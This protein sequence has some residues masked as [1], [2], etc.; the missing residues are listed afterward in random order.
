LVSNI[1]A[2][3]APPYRMVLNRGLPFHDVPSRPDPESQRPLI[4]MRA[5]RSAGL[6]VEIDFAHDTISVW[7]P[8]MTVP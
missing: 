5:L 8:D 6:K 2:L 1:P 4:G 7:T 3:Q